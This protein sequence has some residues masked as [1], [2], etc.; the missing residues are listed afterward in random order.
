LSY[1]KVLVPYAGVTGVKLEADTPSIL[2]CEAGIHRNSSS[3]A[4]R[5]QALAHHQYCRLQV[6]GRDTCACMPCVGC[7]RGVGGER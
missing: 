3:A 6:C 7:R 2:K 1:Q 5:W 4:E